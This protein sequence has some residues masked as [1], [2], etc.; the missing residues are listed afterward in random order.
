MSARY[1]QRLP[2]VGS[3]ADAF[4]HC[5]PGA[6]PRLHRTASG[7]V[8]GA[9]ELTVEQAIGA[10]ADAAG[11]IRDRARLLERLAERWAL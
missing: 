8:V 3:V 10:V 1:F 4:D 6:V 2:V 9:V 11:K 7:D 5:P